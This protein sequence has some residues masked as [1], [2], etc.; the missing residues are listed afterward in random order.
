MN[1]TPVINRVVNDYL[2]TA[3]RDMVMYIKS[4]YNIEFLYSMVRN[5]FVAGIKLTLDK[6]NNKSEFIKLVKEVYSYESNRDVEEL[7]GRPTKDTGGEI[8]GK[9]TRE[10][11]EY[12]GGE[13]NHTIVGLK[14]G[15]ERYNIFGRVD[16]IILERLQD[17]DE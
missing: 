8:K 2:R 9:S 12:I 4:N 14:R 3:L 5:A 6:S 10:P 16:Y 7:A 15:K 13:E 17:A 11:D 1:K